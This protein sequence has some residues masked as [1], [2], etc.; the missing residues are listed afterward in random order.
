MP[1]G[2][3]EERLTGFFAGDRTGIAA[4]YLFGSFA[5]GRATEKSDVDVAVLYEQA[6]AARLDSPAFKLEEELERVVGRAAEVVVLN[7]APVDLIHRVLRDGKLLFEKNR[8]A[9]I[10][11]EVRAR[12]EYFDLLPILRRYRKAQRAAS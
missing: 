3:L 12:N 2:E 11:F 6:P 8:S 10:R 9:R 5:R 4:V 7:G 1:F